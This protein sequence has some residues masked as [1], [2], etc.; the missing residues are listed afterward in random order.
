MDEPIASG[1]RRILQRRS[2]TAEGS[3]PKVG[4][5]GFRRSYSAA[6][7]ARD[8]LQSDQVSLS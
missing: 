2:V 3:L 7:Q 1:S 8:Q 6:S 5:F 4:S